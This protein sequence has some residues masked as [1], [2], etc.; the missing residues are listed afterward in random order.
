MTA[1]RGT[2]APRKRA[3]SA[4]VKAKIP[5][6]QQKVDGRTFDARRLKALLTGIPD[7]EVQ[8]AVMKRIAA[9]LALAGEK[10]TARQARGEDVDPDQLVRV[11]N[12]RWP[13]HSAS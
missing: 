2:K 11:S 12:A 4:G 10:L 9:S 7:I 6:S 13:A 8:A 1:D 5:G 3:G